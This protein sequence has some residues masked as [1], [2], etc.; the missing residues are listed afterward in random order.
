MSNSFFHGIMFHQFHDNKYFKKIPGSLS[1]KH[2]I[3]II[4]SFNVKNILTPE[5]FIEK[6]S[7]NTLQN[8]HVCL[9]FDDA[10]Q[11][12][13]KIALPVL[14]RFNLKAFFFVQTSIFNSNNYMIEDFKI[15]RNQKFK[16]F[17]SFHKF[18]LSILLKNNY[19]KNQLEVFISSK[20]KIIK[21]MKKKYNFYSLIEIKHRLI[22]DY[23]LSKDDYKKIL[24]KMCKKKKYDIRAHSKKTYFKKENIKKLIKDG[25]YVGLHTHNH[26]M[27][28]TKLN[29]E[30]QKK[31]FYLNYRLLKKITKKVPCCASHPSGK[32]NINSLK[33]L[34]SLKIRLAF[35][36]NMI[37]STL[38][39]NSFLN[40]E[41]PR[42]NASELIFRKK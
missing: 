4:K 38:K 13:I 28:I 29:Y 37:T 1:E 10:L 27:D 7:N 33:I 40:F 34:K 21:D 36:D 25:H 15:F 14:D 35:R 39:K 31:E 12:Q 17:T 23:F 42:E 11:S 2:L 9:T 5:K 26:P 22:R 3:K 24:L 16:N 41:V 18:F 8:F 32:Y 20:K 30:E 6:I 19:I